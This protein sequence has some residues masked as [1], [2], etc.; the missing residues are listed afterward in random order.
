MS[1]FVASKRLYHT[2]DRSE[3][4]EEGDPKAAFLLVGE[5]TELPESEVERLGLRAHFEKAEADPMARTKVR[6]MAA[7]ENGSLEE[8]Q[9]HQ[10][11]LE[12]HELAQRAATRPPVIQVAGDVPTVGIPAPKA[13]DR[14]AEREAPKALEREAPAKAAVS[15]EKK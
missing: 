7:V 10:H 2:L 13:V 9:S 1:N 14:A 12:R 6:L 8:A 4:V 15:Q 5:G 11:A 3:V